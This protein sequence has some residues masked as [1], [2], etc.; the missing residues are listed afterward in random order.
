MIKCE[1]S[2]AENQTSYGPLCALGHKVDGGQF[3]A[4]ISCQV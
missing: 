1:L 2:Q 3:W 4:K